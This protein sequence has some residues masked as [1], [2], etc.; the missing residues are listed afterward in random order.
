MKT[1][2]QLQGENAA[3]LAQV[4]ELRSACQL[5]IDMFKVNDINA[6]NTIETLEDAI[7]ATPQHRLREVR[8]KA[9]RKGYAQALFDHFAG[10]YRTLDKLKDKPDQ[11]ADKIRRGEVE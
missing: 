11:Y 2:E 10:D 9:G 6:P 8:A 7:N 3:L 4:E 1:I 5:A